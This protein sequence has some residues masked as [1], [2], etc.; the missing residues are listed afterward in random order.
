MP[1]VSDHKWF[2]F[3]CQQNGCHSL[4]LGRALREL[5]Y[6]ATHLST[7]H[8]DGTYWCKISKTTLDN[9]RSALTRVGS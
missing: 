6:E 8:E 9:A 5:I 4:I 2:D 3:A 7:S 1:E